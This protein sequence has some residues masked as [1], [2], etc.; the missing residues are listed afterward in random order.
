MTPGPWGCTPAR[1]VLPRLSFC[2]SGECGPV[3]PLGTD[4][5]AG[6][7]THPDCP[8]LLAFPTLPLGVSLLTLELRV[9]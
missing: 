9:S 3:L 6:S 2:M 5:P 8:P 4:L 1:P 7:G